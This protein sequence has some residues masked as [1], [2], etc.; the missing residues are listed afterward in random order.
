MWCTWLDFS[1]DVRTRMS[2]Y[3]QT[4][5]TF[6]YIF[7]WLCQGWL[8]YEMYLLLL[9]CENNHLHSMVTLC[10]I[11]TKEIYKKSGANGT[12]VLTKTVYFA[13]ASIRNSWERVLHCQHMLNSTWKNFFANHVSVINLCSKRRKI[14]TWLSNS[15]KH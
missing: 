9:H 2:K 1:I 8:Y 13:S 14:L 4:M 6:L 5:N 12:S 11:V 10:F 15:L 3:T 7:W